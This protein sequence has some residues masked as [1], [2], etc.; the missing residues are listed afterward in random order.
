VSS[1]SDSPF[2]I[3]DQNGQDVG[4]A[5]DVF[6]GFLF[7]RVGNDALLFFAST[8]GPTATPIDFYHSTADCSD[9][10][11]LTIPG[12]SGFAYYA[13]VRGNTFFYTKV[14][15][16]TA[17]LQV[18]ILA[19]EHFEVNEDATLP[20]VCRPMAMGTAA[21]GAVTMATDPALANLALPLRLK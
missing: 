21:L 10:R 1:A 7:R 2:S 17:T 12:S 15:D 6:G 5:T 16:P 11:Y 8:A 14:T 13:T 3:V 20:G 18:P 4:V 9:S 19:F